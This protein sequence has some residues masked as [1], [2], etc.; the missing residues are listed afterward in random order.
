M[1]AIA[2]EL[3]FGAVFFMLS[4]LFGIY[5]NT[6]TQRKRKNE[7]SAYSVFNENCQAIDG[8]NLMAEQFERMGFRTK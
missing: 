1:Y 7:V 8:A 2:I 3:Q 4:I 6:R 5:F